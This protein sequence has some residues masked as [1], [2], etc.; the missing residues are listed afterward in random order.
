MKDNST[1]DKNI[2]EFFDQKKQTIEDNGFSERVF[3]ALEYMPNHASITS[4]EHFK[5]RFISMNGIIVMLFTLLGFVLFFIFGGYAAVIESLISV[6][7]VVAGTTLV[8]P[9]LILSILFLFCLL[10]ALGKFAIE[11]E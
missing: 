3:A 5:K 9:Q 1:N 2:K 7:N 11:A 4:L 10:F 6:G 8:T